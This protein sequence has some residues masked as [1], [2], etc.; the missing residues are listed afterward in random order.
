[1]KPKLGPPEVSARAGALVQAGV[2]ACFVLSGFAALLYQTAWLR[3]FS[4]VFGTSELAVA[5]VLAAYMGGLALGAAVAGRVVA[6]LRRPVLVYGVLEAGIAGSALAVPALLEIAASLHAWAFGGQPSPPD[7]ARI[8]Q[9]AFYLGVAFVVLAVPTALMGATL[10]LLTRHAVR[11]DR[12]LGP[13]VARLYAANTA[14]AVAGTVGAAFLL[15]PAWGLRGTVWTGVAVNLLVFAVAA[16]LS[17]QAPA[18]GDELRAPRAGGEL[19]APR[20]GEAAEPLAGFARACLLPLLDAARPVSARLCAVFRAQP[21]WILPLVLAS[22]ATAFLYEVLWTRMLTHVL[23]G[24]LRA[25]ATMLAAFLTGIALGGA[26]AG[27]LAASREQA[28]RAFAGCQLAIALLSMAVYAW[29]GLRAPDTRAAAALSAYAAAVLLPATVFIGAT[30]P[31]AVRV[32]ARHER[33]AAAATARVYAWNT[34]GAIAGSVL[35][36]FVV[37]PELGF[38]GSIRLAVA[39]NLGLAASTLACITALP[40]RHAALAA[41]LLGVVALAYRPE[42]PL[43]VIASAGFESERLEVPEELF[44]AV[45]RSSTVLLLREGG[46]FHLRTNGLPEGL[47]RAR[48]SPPGLESAAWLTLLPLAARPDARSLLVIGFGGGV[49]LEAAPPSVSEVDVVELEPQVLEANRVLARRRAADPLAD[50]RVRVVQNDGRN[51][52][53]LT[54]KTYDAIISQ[55]SHPWTAGA[56]HLFTREF[57]RLAR[58]HLESDGVFVQWMDAGLVTEP[59]LRSLAA[60]LASEFPHL[61]LYRPTPVSLV[62]LASAA[63]LEPE[64]SLASSGRP[65]PRSQPDPH[66]GRFGLGSLEDLVAALALDGA[67]VAALAA[68]AAPVTDDANQMA[69]RSRSRGDGL[70]SAELARLLA[71]H[72]PLLDPRSWIHTGLAGQLD[73]VYLAQRL[74]R[75]GQ[76]A[77]VE[78]LAHA[79]ASA[80]LRSTLQGLLLRRAGDAPRAAAAY[81]AAIAADPANAQARYL[82]IRDALERLGSGRAPASVLAFAEGLPGSASAVIEGWRR[83]REGD[84][85]ALARLDPELAGTRRTDAWYVDAVRLRAEWRARATPEAAASALA[86]IDD[87]LHQSGDPELRRLRFECALAIGDADL[88]AES[89]R[90][91]VKGIEDRLARAEG[92]RAALPAAEVERIRSL[93]AGVASRLASPLAADHAGAREVLEHS[94]GVRA[95]LERLASAR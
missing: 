33:E 54:A 65:I 1:V 93:L 34:V 2:V 14:G 70:G 37:I 79:V 52:L 80:S 25:F 86:M 40:L 61:R 50:P 5:T 74:L 7:A 75:V 47:I 44:Y 56:S 15:L 95:H 90:S 13:K 35:A 94:Q 11:S 63:P 3:E 28:A 43:A 27:R 66:F 51:A 92:S 39:V 23:G 42:R 24:S 31:L 71:P 77:R 78:G 81:Q 85:E 36:G 20:A 69:T 9:P 30:F 82:L 10:P 67:G 6:R 32:L 68:G 29:A 16:A 57:V 19:R 46:S 48:G 72:D 26:I 41:G 49:S 8:G 73:F 53:R 76:A 21:V 64:R 91:V 55:P 62:F 88:L 59:L 18:R 38:E 45:G 84:R 60:T 12:E 4:L 83:A 22:G 17:R 58:Q 87:A 89:A